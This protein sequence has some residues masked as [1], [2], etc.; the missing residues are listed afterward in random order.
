VYFLQGWFETLRMEAYL[1]NIHVTMV[2]P[3]PVVSEINK[4]YFYGKKGLVCGINS[5][6]FLHNG[7][8]IIYTIEGL[9]PYSFAVIY[10]K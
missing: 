2:C 8:K 6:L 5:N 3:G 1:D 4:H 10:S 7:K 9:H